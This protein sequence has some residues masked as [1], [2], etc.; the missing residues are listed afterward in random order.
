[1]YS[2]RILPFPLGLID[3]AANW[4]K[5]TLVHYETSWV[6]PTNNSW[7]WDESNPLDP[8]SQF[9]RLGYGILNLGP[10][11]LP[12]GK[13][14]FTSNRDGNFEVYR[15]DADGANTVRLTDNPA[16]DTAPIFSPR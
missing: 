14:A 2:R 3:L 6:C 9:D 7:D 13:I 15:M 4:L 10:M 1:M 5:N 12:G 8:G 16:R 11:P